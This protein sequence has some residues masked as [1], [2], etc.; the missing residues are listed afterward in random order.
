MTDQPIPVEAEP[1]PTQALAV[2]PA[3]AV[4]RALGVDDIIAQVTLIQNVMHKVMK[5]GEHYGRISGCGDKATLLQPGAQ[6]LTMT[7][8]LC[9]EYQIQEVNIERGHKEYRVICTLKSMGTGAFV[10]QGVGCCST[11]ESKYRWRNAELK[12]PKCGKHSIIAGKEEYGGGWLCWKKKDGCG[13]KFAFNDGAIQSQPRDKVENDNP[14]DCYNTVLKMAK[15]R[16][17]VDATITATAASDIFT[18]DVGDNE[19]DPPAPEPPG[20][21]V[22]PAAPQATKPPSTPAPAP[23]AA[24]APASAPG[25]PENGIHHRPATAQTRLW[26]VRE[27]ADCADLA[28]EYFQKCNQLMP[29]ESLPD[30]PLRFVPNSREKLAMLKT[31]LAQFGNGERA[32]PAFEPDWNAE[33]G[34]PP[35][36]PAEV[37][38]KVAKQ[39]EKQNPLWW[40]DVLVP[41]PRKGMRAS[42]YVGKEDTLGSLFDLR[43]GQDEEAQA[44]RQRLWGLVEYRSDPNNLTNK[45][46]SKRKPTDVDIAFAKALVAFKQW[47]DDNH[48]GEK[49]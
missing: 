7:F 38:P 2:R 22:P 29:N 36:K 40:R 41:I 1:I 23:K 20:A 16:A 44:A 33:G 32:E 37:A 49:L 46:G 14:A 13:A 43:H 17:F 5:E 26:M 25:K 48:R 35:K 12:C 30:L 18:Q 42:E 9:P 47:F 3:Q 4:D 15:K 45:D 11:M 19:E 31:R 6:K 34:P 10:G 39:A 21:K 24:P 27:L 8:R 28:K